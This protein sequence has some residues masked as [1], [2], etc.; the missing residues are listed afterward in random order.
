VTV[1]VVLGV[2]MA[3]TYALLNG[4]N[5]AAAAVAMPVVTRV[6]RPGPAVVVAAVFNFLGPLLAGAAVAGLIAGIVKVEGPEGV[7]IVGAGLTSAVAWCAFGWWRGLPTSAGHALIGGLVGA[8]LAADGSSGVHWGGVDGL[9]PTGVI[10]ALFALVFSVLL[11]LVGGVAAERLARRALRRAAK[12]AE[13]GVAAGEWVAAA[14]LA[15]GH[16][17]NDGAKSMGAIGA[18]LFAAG[19]EPTDGSPPWA[20]LAVATA[21]TVGTALGGWSIVRTIGRRLVHMHSVDGL[22]AQGS[23]ALVVLT[24]TFVGAPVSTTQVLASSVVGSGVGRHR[25][26]HVRWSIAVHIAVSWVIT[27][28]VSAVG[29][30]VLLPLWRWLA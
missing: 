25:R 15:F 17:A 27:L 29:A 14:A 4:V 19:L 28:P 3:L 10:G 2:A 13:R 21:L 22:V 30:A 24:S 11:G 1:A 20:R 12:P 23:S 6:A 7:A 8:A 5:D 18:I 26:H 16:G 9:K